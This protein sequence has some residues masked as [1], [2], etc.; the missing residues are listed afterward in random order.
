[1]TELTLDQLQIDCNYVVSKA[2]EMST[3]AGFYFDVISFTG[4]RVN[5]VCQLNRWGNVITGESFLQTSKRGGI[6]YFPAGTIPTEYKALWGSDPLRGSYMSVQ[7]M[8]RIHSAFTAYPS[9]MVKDK[10]ISVHIFRH[11]KIKT[12]YN[13]GLNPLEIANSFGYSDAE[14]AQYYIDSIIYLP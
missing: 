14:T 10:P 5:E 2:R 8:R 7:N 9:A 11:V 6:R 4:C 1:M 12:L 13:E 3:F